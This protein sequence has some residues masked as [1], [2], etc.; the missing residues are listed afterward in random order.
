MKTITKIAVLNFIKSVLYLLIAVLAGFLLGILVAG[1]WV[2]QALSLDCRPETASVH[3][4]RR[5][6]KSC[7]DIKR[8]T[9]YA[10]TRLRPRY[11]DLSDEKFSAPLGKV[12]LV[13]LDKRWWWSL[14]GG[15]IVDKIQ[16]STI[17]VGH[18]RVGYFVKTANNMVSMCHELGHVFE[19]AF[20]NA[21]TPLDNGGH[22]GWEKP[23]LG[24]QYLCDPYEV[25]RDL[26]LP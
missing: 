22:E 14:F 19:H 7:A 8:L 12:Y 24:I 13:V 9:A 23:P 21:G 20:H 2:P 4:V 25:E 26:E 11:V 10:L 5:G 18:G 17:A 6:P 1:G 15:G 16:G 3:V